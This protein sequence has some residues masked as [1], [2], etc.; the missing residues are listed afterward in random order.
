MRKQVV[1][2]GLIL[3]GGLVCP[4]QTSSVTGEWR[5]M[6]TN[7]AGLVFTA[8]MT[9][10]AGPS[11]KTCAVISAGG[12][13]GKIVWTLRKAGTNAP[14]DLPVRLGQRARSW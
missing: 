13:R 1:L 14:R 9:L 4:A 12:I 7:P 5:G 6:W 11:C 3:L 2:A 10:E 8:S